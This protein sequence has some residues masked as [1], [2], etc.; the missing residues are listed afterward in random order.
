MTAM[1]ISADHC[2]YTLDNIQRQGQK[3]AGLHEKNKG[4][5]ETAVLG[6][7]PTTI[8]VYGSCRYGKN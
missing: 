1:S 3:A 6:W 4:D 8:S 2:D 7:A 5:V